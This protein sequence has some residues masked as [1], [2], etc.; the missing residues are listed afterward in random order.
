MFI[1]Y[2]FFC[3]TLYCFYTFSKI[4]FNKE[5]FL[6]MFERE[7]GE[8]ANIKFFLVT[9]LL[10]NLLAWPIMMVN[11]INNTKDM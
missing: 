3:G 4:L 5:Y 7:F 11:E 8:N 9:M 2:Y 1:F 10:T 6:M